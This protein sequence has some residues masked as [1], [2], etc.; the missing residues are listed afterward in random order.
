[1]AKALRVTLTFILAVVS[2]DC[3]FLPLL[4]A[5]SID[6]V[7]IDI[8]VLNPPIVFKA[9]GRWDMAYELRISSLADVGDTTISSIQLLDPSGKPLVDISGD[10]LKG[11]LRLIAKT[12]CE[13]SSGARSSSKLHKTLANMIVFKWLGI[14]SKSRSILCSRHPSKWQMY[15]LRIAGAGSAQVA[16]ANW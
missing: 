14:V 16:A 5:Q 1:M 6:V 9:D 10:A 3:G 2:V 15:W 12:S 4:R 7:P 11:F 8:S 13:I